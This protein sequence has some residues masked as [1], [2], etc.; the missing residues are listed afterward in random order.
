MLLA[1]AGKA[2]VHLP[3]DLPLAGYRPFGR[4]ASQAGTPLHVRSLLLEV[5]GLRTAV[6]VMELMTLPPA[7]AEAVS[8][9]L[10]AEGAGCALVAATH[11]HS[12]PGGYDRELIQQAVAIGRYDERLVEAILDAVSASLAAAGA[13]LDRAELAIGEVRRPLNTNRDRP[14]HGTDDRLTTIRLRRPDGSRIAEVVRFA[15]HP[16]L[17]PRP[18]G[19]AGDW[20]GAAMERLEEVEGGVAFVLQGAVGDARAAPVREPAVARIDDARAASTDGAVGL[21]AGEAPSPAGSGSSGRGL[22][23]DEEGAAATVRSADP[24]R[25]APTAAAMASSEPVVA[26]ANELASEAGRLRAHEVALP[27]TLGCAEAE[28]DLPPPELHAVVPWPLGRLLS[29]LASLVAPTAA[30]T[31]ALRLDDLILLGVPAEPTAG[32]A[33]LAEARPAEDGLRGRIVSLAQGYAGYAPLP[34]DIVDRVFS[35][36]YSWF[37][38]KLAGRLEDGSRAAADALLARPIGAHERS[39]RPDDPGRSDGS[40]GRQ[41]R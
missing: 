14:G 35:S 30:R 41:D 34:A 5:A 27:L 37:G 6:V 40:T 31:V 26:F 10:R 17:T 8:A 38:S 13:D 19:P 23:T 11:T 36:R 33:A 2:E 16:T 1:G 18:I 3:P 29:N 24:A 28:F 39:D 25:S 20:P 15:A 32:A 9:R 12:G 4:K 21:P 7:L 22:G